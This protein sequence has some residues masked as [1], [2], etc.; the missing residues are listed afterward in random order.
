MKQIYHAL[1]YEVFHTALLCG[2]SML[3][4]FYYQLRM[5][6]GNSLSLVLNFYVTCYTEVEWRY[7]IKLVREVTF[8]ASNLG[9]A[10]PLKLV[11]A[12]VLI[13]HNLAQNPLPNKGCCPSNLHACVI[14]FCMFMIEDIIITTQC[15]QLVTEA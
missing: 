10:I 11:V 2:L 12:D 3:A 5:E 8:Y 15:I 6:Y 9:M 14:G 13:I 4:I 7:M 1:Q